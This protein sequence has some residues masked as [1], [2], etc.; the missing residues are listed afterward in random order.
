[1]VCTPFLLAAVFDR[2]GQTVSARTYYTQ[3]VEMNGNGR[4]LVDRYWLAPTLFRL[5]ELY[6]NAG[7][8]RHATEYYGRFVDLWKNADPE[9]QQRVADARG[10]IDRLNRAN[11]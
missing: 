9:L 8:V 7:D 5:G 4:T 11:R 1:M 2:A 3:Y 6:E 10:R